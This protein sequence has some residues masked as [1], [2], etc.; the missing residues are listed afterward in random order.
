LALE[1]GEQ[2][3]SKTT[4]FEALALRPTP[5]RYKAKTAVALQVGLAVPNQEEINQVFLLSTMLY[6]AILGVHFRRQEQ[7]KTA[8]TLEFPPTTKPS[9]YKKTL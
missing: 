3:V 8:N 6:K 9:I 5:S 4:L 1:F 2:L 7:K